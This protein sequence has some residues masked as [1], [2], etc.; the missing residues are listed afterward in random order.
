DGVSY[1][2]VVVPGTPTDG[3]TLD[4]Y[5]ASKQPGESK[6]AKHMILFQPSGQELVVNEAYIVSNNGKTAWNDPVDGTLHFFVPEAAKDSIH[7]SATP[8]GGQP[9]RQPAEKVGRSDIYKLNFAMRPGETRVDLDYKLPYTEGA[10]YSGKVVSGD[11]NTYLIIPNGV[12][13]KGDNLADLGQEPRTQAHIF[14]LKGTSYEVQFTG[15]AAPQAAEDSSGSQD[16]QPPVQQIM[17]R[18]YDKAKLI[19]A[20]AFGILALGFVLLYR[21][22]AKE[23]NERGRR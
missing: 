4:I 1:N 6:V 15:A 8:P 23:A 12:T 14:G 3:L 13:I 20:L 16:G 9:L 19:L 5:N 7:A 2:K 10:P 17:P 21:M 22:P 18:L 11:D